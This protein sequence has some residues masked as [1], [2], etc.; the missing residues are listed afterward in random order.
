MAAAAL[1]GADL[2][3]PGDGWHV[4]AG[5]AKG[6]SF[7]YAVCETECAEVSLDFR[8]LLDSHG[9]RLWVVQAQES[10]VGQV[11]LLDADTMD[12]R[13]AAYDFGL[14]GSLSRTLLRLAEFAPPHDPKSLETGSVWGRVHWHAG[15]D[16]HLAVAHRDSAGVAGEVHGAAVLQHSALETSTAVVSAQFPFPLSALEYGALQAVPDPPAKF[17]YE[18]LEYRRGGQD[19]CGGPEGDGTPNGDAGVPVRGA[20]PA[21]GGAPFMLRGAPAP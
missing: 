18:L 11:L 21:P 6:D 20:I 1:A 17:A 14:S 13:P 16:S 2:Q 10:G 4:G 8:D 19:A 3:L 12:L 7:T 5:L 15:P 9:R